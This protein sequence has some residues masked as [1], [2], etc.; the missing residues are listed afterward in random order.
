M[1]YVEDH[2]FL[3]LTPVNWLQLCGL[4]FIAIT[5]LQAGLDKAFDY[6]GNKSYF[7]SHFKNTILAKTAPLLLP[8]IM[9]MEISSGILAIIGGICIFCKNFEIA[10]YASM[11]ALLTL[12]CL[13]A[14]Q[15][16]GKFYGE[17]A[18]IVPYMIIVFLS[19]MTLL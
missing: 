13:F 2:I 11:L 14:G 4:L 19:C 15:R 3:G 7:T 18:G 5:F 9:I 16:I 10:F 8:V 12:L 1:R 17:A 6:P